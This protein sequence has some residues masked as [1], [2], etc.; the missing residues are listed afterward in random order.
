MPQGLKRKV[1]QE[2]NLPDEEKRYAADKHHCAGRTAR[3]YPAV[4]RIGELG[5]AAGNFSAP[6]LKKL[7]HPV[8]RLHAIRPKQTEAHE[9]HR[10]TD[11]AEHAYIGHRHRELQKTEYAAQSPLLF[12]VYGFQAND[13]EFL[14]AG[15]GL[16]FHFIPDIFSEKRFS[17]RR[18][19]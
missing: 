2:Q 3:L 12:F 14:D 17:D 13:L 4:E 16:N 19:G 11:R 10:F 7:A 1:D 15:R 8:D 5:I 6:N 18:G 9:S